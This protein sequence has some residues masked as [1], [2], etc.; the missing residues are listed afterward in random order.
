MRRYAA[1]TDQ[2]LRMAAEAVSGNEFAATTRALPVAD[3]SALERLP[4]NIETVRKIRSTPRRLDRLNY[5]GREIAP[6]GPLCQ[7]E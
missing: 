4:R 6:L 5:L 7:H 1:V 2:T 3:R